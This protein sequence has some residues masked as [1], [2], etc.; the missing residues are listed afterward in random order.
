MENKQ[1]TGMKSHFHNKFN[2]GHNKLLLYSMEKGNTATFATKLN[3][4]L[5]K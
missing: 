5:Q 1:A 3:M 2:Y 4:R